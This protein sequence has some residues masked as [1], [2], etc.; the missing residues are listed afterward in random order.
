MTPVR[1]FIVGRF[2]DDLEVAEAQGDGSAPS[3]EGKPGGE[4]GG[5]QG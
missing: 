3:E 4:E 5:P 2:S 1:M